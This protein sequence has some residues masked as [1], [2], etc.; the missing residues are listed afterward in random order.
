MPID[1]ATQIAIDRPR[2]EVA[3]YASEPDN[4]T[5]W[6]ARIESATWETP[7]PL[8][9]GSRFA[10]EAR[11]LG[12]RL[13]YVYEVREH[14]PAERLVMS[15]DDGPFPMETT[16][17]WEDG[18]EGETVMR[19]RNRGAPTGFSRLLSPLMAPAVRR[20]NRGDLERLKEQLE[21]TAA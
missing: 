19:L 17:T 21:Q 6:Y 11:F 1:V 2:E 20:A 9:V 5:A 7:R 15:S 14:L 13:S 18:M 10:F 16:Y 3:A 4:A 12:R 8:S